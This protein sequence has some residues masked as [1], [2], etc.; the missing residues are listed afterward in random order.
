M[1]NRKKKRSVNPDLAKRDT[2]R[3]KYADDLIVEMTGQAYIDGASHEE[4]GELQA[5]IKNGTYMRGD[6][7]RKVASW[8]D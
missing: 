1:A 8:Y 4:V 2:E 3:K 5:Q 6:W 7:E